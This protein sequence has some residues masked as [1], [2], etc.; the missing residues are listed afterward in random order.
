MNTTGWSA[1]AAN[2]AAAGTIGGGLRITSL[3]ASLSI[4]SV[5][6]G[7]AYQT[8]LS[9]GKWKKQKSDGAAVAAS[10]TVDAFKILLT[11]PIAETYDVVY[12]AHVEG[13]GWQRR[14][15][16]GETA[17]VEGSGK[18]IDALKISIVSKK[19]ASGWIWDDGW[20]YC[21]SGVRK[22][23]TWLE[24]NEH[25]IDIALAGKQRYWLDSNGKLAVDRYVSPKNSAD[26]AAG[27]TAYATS[28]GYVARGKYTNGDGMLLADPA[29]GAL[30]TKTK[31]LT[32][33]AFDGKNQTYR[34]AKKSGTPIAVV[35]TGLFKV[36]KKKYFGWTDERG[37]LFKSGIRCIGKTWYQA[38][39]KGV[40][41]NIDNEKT[42]L[43]E[44][45]VKWTVK[46]AKNNKHGYSQYNR[47]GPDYDCSSLVCAS[48]LAVGFP[49]SGA[50]WTGNMKKCLKKIGFKWHKGTTGIQRGDILLV[51]NS[52]HQQHC[53]KNFLH[54]AL[55]Y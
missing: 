23:S 11:G 2:G 46:I 51:H 50:S 36:G 41:T 38:D 33:N 53:S 31:W 42:R 14:M 26:A 8:H 19:K 52:Q 28:Q 1:Q 13:I 5:S 43:I 49:N 9:N 29:T 54:N 40:L 44:R 47:W 48:L 27:L 10:K 25:P 3:K 39:A 34:V 6:G 22:T 24:T 30:P 16:N 21:S 20:T 45:Y 7:I 32:T 17:G 35:K 15:R 55:L 12:R 4:D 18:R 37:Y